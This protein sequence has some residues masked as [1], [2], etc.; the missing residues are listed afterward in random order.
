VRLPAILLTSGLLLAGTSGFLTSAAMS[1]SEESERM[2]TITLSA[3]PPGPPGP[4]GE[5][6]PAGPA[7]ERG[8]VGPAG[9]VGPPGPAG[10]MSCKAG[11]S[12]GEL[13]INHPGGH[14][15]LWTCIE[16]EDE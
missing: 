1:Q 15:T 16:E 14:V 5:Q 9:P 12:R 8:P 6:G 7:G 3:G 10:A 4:A 11:F 13:R 2:V